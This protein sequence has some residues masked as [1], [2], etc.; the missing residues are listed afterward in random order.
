MLSGGGEGKALAAELAADPAIFVPGSREKALADQLARAEGAGL[1][2][3]EERLAAAL[4]GREP[5]SSC[6]CSTM[7]GFGE[8][9]DAGTD[10]R[11]PAALWARFPDRHAVRRVYVARLTRM[12]VDLAS[13]E[14]YADALRLVE[15]CLQLEPHETLH[16]QNRAA[17]FTLLREPGAYHDAWFELDRH[18]F[19]L[20]LL[21]ELT[22][23]HALRL[24]APHRLFAQHARLAGEGSA[25]ARERQEAGIADGNDANQ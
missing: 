20:A 25:A 14:K 19:R 7:T 22:P 2:Q 1:E 21:G 9:L 13:R 10:R 23:A 17:L 3:L 15:R 18:H 16:Y 12:A 11:C 8:G 6:C 4:P 5:R 24:A